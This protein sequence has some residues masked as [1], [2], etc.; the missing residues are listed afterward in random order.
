MITIQSK[1]HY[2]CPCCFNEGDMQIR[3]SYFEAEEGQHFVCLIAKCS[4]CNRLVRL[5]FEL[6][7]IGPLN[8]AGGKINIKG[9]K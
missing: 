4:H 9:E 3:E 8:G 1:F 2:P 7:S 5:K 6:K